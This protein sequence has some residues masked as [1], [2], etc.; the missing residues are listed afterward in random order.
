MRAKGPLRTILI[1]DSNIGTGMPDGLYE[2]SWGYSVKVGRGDAARIHEPGTARHG[3]ITGSLLTMDVGVNNLLGWLDLPD[4][5]VWAMATLAPARLMGLDRKGD[6]Q[7]GSD[8]DLVLWDETTGTHKAAAT[9]VGG[10][11]AHT[12]E[13]TLQEAIH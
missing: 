8:A 12:S 2:T 10:K 4:H 9:W 7:V 13:P 3:G 6:I 11:L 1:T 5:D